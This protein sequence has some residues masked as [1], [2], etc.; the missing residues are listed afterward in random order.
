MNPKISII[1]P[2]FG[3]ADEKLLT[4]CLSS[5]HSQN[6][7][8]QVY[9]IIIADDNGQ[10]VYAARNNGIIQAK[11]NYI[12]FVDADDYLFPGTLDKCLSVLDKKQPDMLSFRFRHTNENETSEPENQSCKE[13]YYPSGADYMFHNNYFGT[14][15][16]Y[17]IRRELILNNNLSFCLRTH[18]QDE[19]FCAEAYFTAG[20]IIDLSLT[21]YA[22][23]KQKNSLV[24]HRG[25]SQRQ[26]R[27]S[28]F[29]H[30]LTALQ[31]FLK[32]HPE[33]T[34]LQVKALNRRIHFL[35]IDF[36][37]QLLRNHCSFS[38]FRQQVRDLAENNLLPLPANKYNIK[39]MLAQPVVNLLVF[40]FYSLNRI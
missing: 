6:I 20:P 31:V 23:C 34:E 21:V 13:I 33:A 5:I 1:I 9:E 8:R 11:G 26:E 19:I 12:F 25:A 10:G 35:T 28:D 18:H 36:L 38:Q 27:I 22:Y 4:R 37:C 14:V 40:P 17:F 16:R 7:D 29:R 24:H 15:W 3:K 30:I 39:Y 32:N 2:F